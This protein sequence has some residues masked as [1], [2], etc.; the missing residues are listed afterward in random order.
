MN[1]KILV[2]TIA[3]TIILGGALGAGAMTDNF[4]TVGINTEET[5]ASKTAGESKVM[6]MKEAKDLALAEYDGVVE[7]IE[8]DKEWRKDIYEIEMKDGETEYDIDLDA[9]TGEFVKVKEEKDDDDDDDDDRAGDGQNVKEEDLITEE[10]AIDIATK[11]V[12]GTVSK[13]ERD[14]EDN[15]VEYDIE[16]QT[17]KGEADIE[18]NAETGEIISVEQDQN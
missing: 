1:K 10:E 2:G 13:V 15:R 7:S 11:E 9:V 3:S 18:I 6:S 17:D 14:H 4:R 16:I 5:G 12:P 8:L